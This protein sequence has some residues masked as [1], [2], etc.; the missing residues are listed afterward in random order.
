MIR[1]IRLVSRFMSQPG[2]QTIVI[3][4]LTNTSRSKSN[5]AIKFSQLMGYSMRNVFLKKSYTKFGGQKSYTKSKLGISLD[6]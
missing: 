3:H 4:I 2:K 6:Q 5:Q 1:K